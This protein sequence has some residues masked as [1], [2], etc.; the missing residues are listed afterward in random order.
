VCAG[1]RCAAGVSVEGARSAIVT[2]AATA[3]VT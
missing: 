2:A 3:A 1:G